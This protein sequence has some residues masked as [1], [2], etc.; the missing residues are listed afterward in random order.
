MAEPVAAD[1]AVAVAVLRLSLLAAAAVAVLRLSPC[2]VPVA[3]SAAV[4]VLRLSLLA[5]AAVAGLRLS[6]L[7]AVAAAA[8]DRA[9]VAVLRLSL[10]AAA[11]VAA[12]RVG[13]ADRAE[14]PSE[15]LR[16][17]RLT[18]CPSDR[19]IKPPPREFLDKD[20]VQCPSGLCTAGLVRVGHFAG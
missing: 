7:A 2:A 17:T 10:L 18:Y 11:A 16:Q 15:N 12:G 13:A 9:A 6:L 8:A 4:A 19:Q 1:I 3:P 20:S 5:A 14:H